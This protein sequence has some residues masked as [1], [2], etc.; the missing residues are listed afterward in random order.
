MTNVSDG[1]RDSL[2]SFSRRPGR[3]PL[4]CAVALFLCGCQ[5]ATPWWD[6]E[7]QVN[8]KGVLDLRGKPW[9]PKALELGEG[10]QFLVK[11]QEPGGGWMLVRR[12][13]LTGKRANPGPAVVWIIDDDGDMTPAPRAAPGA[14]P[15]AGMDA[16]PAPQPDHDSDCYVVDYDAD[17]LVDRMV[18]YM[19]L[20]GRPDEMD[21][22]YFVK[23]E[24]RRAWFWEDLDRDTVMWSLAN[25]EYNANCFTS[26]PYGD[27]ML[28]MN[29]Y[30]PER[31]CWWPISECPFAFYD[32]DGDG[33]S[34][35]VVR[36]SAAP[37][38][39]DASKDADFANDAA[40]YEGP[41]YP[42]LRTI[43]VVNIRYS[44]DI[45]DLSSDALPLHHDIGFN[46]TGKLPYDFPGMR[47][48]H[49]LRR[50][51]Q[52]TICAPHSACR[53]I[54]ESYP[55]EQTGFS[56]REFED[57]M[58]AIG[59]P[60][61][62]DRDWRWEGVFWIWARRIMHNTGGP[63]Q[64]WNMRREFR[65]TPS[66]RRE[67][68]YSEI[69]RRIHLKGAT[70]GW[71]EIGCMG[72]RAPIG[73]Q[74]MFDTDGDGYFDRWEVYAAG[75]P[76]PVRVTTVYDPRARSVPADWKRLGEFYTETVLPEA[77]RANE[78]LIAAMSNVR[79]FTPPETLTRALASATCDTERRYVLDIIRE[80]QYTA[81][82]AA[83][84]SGSSELFDPAGGGDLR[85][86][87]E[88]LDASTRA[89]VFAGTLARMDQAYGEGRFDR[90]CAM[91]PALAGGAGTAK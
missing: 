53:R 21:I 79:P 89:W 65:P 1:K 34:E 40:R 46:M 31:R 9:W 28:Y 54:S 75:R 25:Y 57:G 47:H 61:Y 71:I 36:F 4:A 35:A 78:M 86:R 15:D 20:D 70:E 55:A 62:A 90:V 81:L 52:T 27:N 39:F 29:R 33:Q 7:T 18:D 68:Y 26:D 73:E 74:R 76:V 42:E 30:D 14:M 56:W 84:L 59:N 63:V 8:D 83:L 23:G 16:R 11:S 19:H 10:Q 60:P 37:I 44:I 6:R 41:F 48:Y 67:L 85:G 82:R 80:Q 3:G 43:G 51:P 45:D 66:T 91:L 49:P 64:R 87:R 5:A 24:L 72:D 22:R 32:T 2:S 13:R 12:E 77:I 38:G 88:Q 17:G 50:S 69:D 58:I